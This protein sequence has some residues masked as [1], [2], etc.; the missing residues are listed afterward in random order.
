MSENKQTNGLKPTTCLLESDLI[1]LAV[2]LRFKP[3]VPALFSDG[4]RDPSSSLARH[5]T[6]ALPGREN[7]G[8]KDN[9]GRVNKF[10]FCYYLL[11]T[12]LK[13]SSLE[14]N[15]SLFFTR[16]KTSDYC[17]IKVNSFLFQNQLIRRYAT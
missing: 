5:V 12:K 13:I 3:L 14:N 8:W 15:L 16:F 9:F 11:I 4:P 7:I 6:Q 17:Y 1:R 2:V 10:L